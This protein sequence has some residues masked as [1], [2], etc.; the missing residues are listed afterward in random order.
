MANG[1]GGD[2][3]GG[4]GNRDGSGGDGGDGGVVVEKAAH[5][6]H[7]RRCRAKVNAKFEELRAVLPPPPASVELKFKAQV[8]DWTITC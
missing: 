3:G 7:T 4:D 8:L 1:G 6:S 2:D 5:N